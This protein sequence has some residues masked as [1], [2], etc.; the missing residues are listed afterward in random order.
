MGGTSKSGYEYWIG[1][2][3]KPA[4]LQA[5]QGIG[6]FARSAGFF[7]FR[8]DLGFYCQGDK[9]RNFGARL[10]RR[11]PW[12]RRKVRRSAGKPDGT[13]GNPGV[14]PARCPSQFGDNWGEIGRSC[15][16][17]IRVLAGPANFIFVSMVGHTAL[18][19]P[20]RESDSGLSRAQVDRGHTESCNHLPPSFREWFRSV[21]GQPCSQPGWR[22]PGGIAGAGSD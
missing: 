7:R 16:R 19:R 20:A 18:S 10:T 8:G 5:N 17:G 12:R 13:R 2:G 21:W 11:L 14:R 3:T 22:Q 1:R 4:G 15:G 6:V 9:Y